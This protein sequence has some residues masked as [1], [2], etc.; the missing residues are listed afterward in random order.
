MLPLLVTQ[1]FRSNAGS[2]FPVSEAPHLQ[3]L[4]VY[5]C[6]ERLV[7][8]LKCHSLSLAPVFFPFFITYKFWQRCLYC[9]VITT[10]PISRLTFLFVRG[11]EKAISWE[12]TDLLVLSNKQGF[13]SILESFFYLNILLPLLTENRSIFK[14]NNVA[15]FQ[16][17]LFSADFIHFHLSLFTTKETPGPYWI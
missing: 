4:Q 8:R 13:I 6:N 9:T 15:L 3:T 14:N 7:P 10:Y 16:I 1:P 12:S 5:P 11:E 2:S 17:I